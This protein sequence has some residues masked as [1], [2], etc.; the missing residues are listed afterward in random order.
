MNN[1]LKPCPFC[2]GKA[3]L[4]YGYFFDNGNWRIPVTTYQVACLCG[5]KTR[6]LGTSR[7]AIEEWNNQ[8]EPYPGPAFYNS[9][10][11]E[12]EKYSTGG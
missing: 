12:K 11:I 1:E 7:E 10:I 4:Y 6:V 8:L 3:T 9:V 5:V 2:G